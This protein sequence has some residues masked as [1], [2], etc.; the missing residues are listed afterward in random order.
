MNA[1][2]TMKKDLKKN[3]RRQSL[4]LDKFGLRVRSAHREEYGRLVIEARELREGIKWL[5]ENVYQG[6]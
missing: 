6:V 4:C 5:K 1:L 3:Q 2:E